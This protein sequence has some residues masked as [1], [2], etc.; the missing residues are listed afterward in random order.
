MVNVGLEKLDGKAD[1]LVVS[2]TPNEALVREWQEHDI[3]KYVAVIAG[4]EMG[5]KAEHLEYA[6]KGKYKENHVLMIGDAP[7]DMKAAKANNALFYP[8]N[9][10]QE[11]NSWKRFHDEAFNKFINGEYAGDYEAKVI[12]E[13][14]EY[15]PE[16]PHWLE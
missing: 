16:K 7:G 5:K 9:P 12:A 1:M 4:Q 3:E 6:T 8:I 2:A 11:D 15:L 10:G 14:D 13:F